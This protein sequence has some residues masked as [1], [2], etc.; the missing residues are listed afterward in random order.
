MPGNFPENYSAFAAL[1]AGMK[2]TSIRVRR[3][4]TAFVRFRVRRRNG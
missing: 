4:T 2:A 1:A 3:E